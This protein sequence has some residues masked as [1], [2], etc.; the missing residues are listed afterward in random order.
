M[1]EVRSYNYC[2]TIQV[3]FSTS[4]GVHTFWRLN[5]KFQLNFNSGYKLREKQ[6]NKNK[7]TKLCFS[8]ASDD[9]TEF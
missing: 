9:T 3:W 6:T 2:I 4:E 7:S 5:L 8:Y 1:L